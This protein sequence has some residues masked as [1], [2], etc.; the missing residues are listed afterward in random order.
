M[1]AGIDVESVAVFQ[2][3][4]ILEA[5]LYRNSWVAFGNRLL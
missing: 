4:Y 2:C 5:E 1:V 3:K